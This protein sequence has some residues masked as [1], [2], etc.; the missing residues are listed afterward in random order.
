MPDNRGKRPA[1]LVCKECGHPT[2]VPN[3][4]QT[5]PLKDVSRK[6]QG[7]QPDTIKKALNRLKEEMG[8]GIP[9]NM[10]ERDE[11]KEAEYQELQSEG[12][13]TAKLCEGYVEG[14]IS[15]ATA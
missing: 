6:M 8:F 7:P 2:V 15:A 9:D 13:E 10:G 5:T 11:E 3:N 4:A 14:Y 12:Q 1:F